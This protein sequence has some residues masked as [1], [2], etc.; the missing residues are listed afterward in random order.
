MVRSALLRSSPLVLIALLAASL[1]A[2]MPQAPPPPAPPVG[3][4][5]A[6]PATYYCVVHPE[7][8]GTEAG[9]CRKCGNPLF[10]GDPWAQPEYLVDLQTDPRGPRPGQ[11]FTIRVAIVDPVSRAPVMDFNVI[12]ERRLHLVVVGQDLGS[13]THLHPEQHP[14]GSWTVSHTVP[15]PGFYRAFVRFS[16]F[17][18]LPQ[19]LART[20]ATNGFTGD[21]TTSVPRLVPDRARAVVVGDVRVALAVDPDPIRAGL[22][23][24]L[25]YELTAGG[26]PVTDLEPYD[27]G[28]GHAFV[29]SEDALDSV[30]ADAIEGVPADEIDPRGG[31]QLRFD[32]TFPRAGRYR[33]WLQFKRHGVVW[34]APLTVEALPREIPQG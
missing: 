12:Q 9:I 14:D 10:P 20:F 32:A 30:R 26:R 19:V 3:R 17:A 5:R 18:G 13:F 11:P 33:V 22:T 28:W 25:R 7:V 31:P 6:T 27:N 21:L 23:G 24:K 8:K 2:A 4:E 1:R 15:R 29:L 16:P 34:T